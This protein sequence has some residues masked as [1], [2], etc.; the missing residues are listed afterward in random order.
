[1]W[2]IVQIF[3]G[4]YG[5]E[6]S[7]I[8]TCAL[9][10]RD[11]AG[12]TVNLT[13]DDDWLTFA[14]LAE[15]DDFD[16]EIFDVCDT[17][18]NP[19]GSLVERSHAHKYGIRHRTAHIWVVRE[20]EGRKQVL[21][22]KRAMNKDSFPG[23]FDTSSSGHIQAGD[24]PLE[25]ALRELYEELGI[26]AHEEDLQYAGYFDVKYEKEFHGKL[27]KDNE[28]AFVYCYDLPVDITQLTL[29]KEEL[30]S[31]EWFDLDEVTAACAV[32]DQKFCVP[33]GGLKVIREF[34]EK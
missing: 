21:L 16:K 26:S 6:E 5:C 4:E 24:E 34:L 1:M 3:D 12:C 10:L 27:F 14:G 13:V 30:D 29:Q 28:Y 9:T 7:D 2:K 25:S 17:D 20:Y 31:V 23:R 19:L 22:Q 15:G 18:G 8:K 11:E 32:H 33:G